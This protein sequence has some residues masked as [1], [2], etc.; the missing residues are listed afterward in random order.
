MSASNSQGPLLGSEKAEIS[1][2]LSSQ[3]VIESQVQVALA[4][5]RE[6]KDGLACPNCGTNHLVGELAC[7][8]CGVL[9]T[10][11]GKTDKLELTDQL[12]TQHKHWPIGEAF[13]SQHKKIFLE[14]E[15]QQLQL[16][17]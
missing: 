13:T 12:T 5:T 2:T 1:L 4:L 6:H 16:P 11:S 9:F 17:A 8:N 14:I 15:G 10:N 3:D 7:A